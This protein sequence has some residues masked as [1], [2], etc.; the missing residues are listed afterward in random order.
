[1]MS[2][3][4][5]HQS[6]GNPPCP[7]SPLDLLTT[8]PHGIT[9]V[10][11]KMKSQLPLVR[12]VLTHQLLHADD[13]RI[14]LQF[15][16]VKKLWSLYA[17][18]ERQQEYAKANHA[19]VGMPPPGVDHQFRS[20]GTR[21]NYDWCSTEGLPQLLSLIKASNA[22]ET[23]CW[24]TISQIIND[25]SK[26]M[27]VEALVRLRS[28][29][30]TAGVYVLVF[31]TS[32]EDAETTHFNEMCDEYL[33]VEECEPDMNYNAAFS[34]D[35]YGLRDLNALGIGKTLCNVRYEGMAVKHTYAPFVAADFKT[36]AMW[37]LRG[38]GLSFS[39]IGAK[40]DLDKSN[41]LRKLA[42]LPRPRLVKVADD[43]LESLGDYL[44]AGI[45]KSTEKKSQDE[46]DDI[47]E[48]E[49]DM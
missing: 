28:A 12:S 4:P 20:F 3:S 8:V 23:P 17:G 41:V 11:V 2:I 49:E 40:V 37:T 42:K 34:I 44:E 14:G 32:D 21:G 33:E 38:M 36:R 19:A 31:L 47:E 45:A 25:S 24:Y 5:N 27:Q 6:S 35:C 16:L 1:M 30:K 15:P 7:A 29:A 22:I 9:F 46:D 13:K 48:D 39:E 18:S 10:R 26:V 43:W